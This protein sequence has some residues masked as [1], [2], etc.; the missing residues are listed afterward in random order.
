MRKNWMRVVVF[1]VCILCL[2]GCNAGNVFSG[3]SMEGLQST[4]QQMQKRG[5]VNRQQAIDAVKVFWDDASEFFQNKLSSASLW[6]PA[7]TEEPVFVKGEE[8]VPAPTR[9]QPD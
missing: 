3:I 4:L 9:P 5:E 1:V 7:K 2:A 8:D 6:Q